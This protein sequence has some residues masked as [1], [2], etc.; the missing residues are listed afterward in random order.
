MLSYVE[1][2]ND[3]PGEEDPASFVEETVPDSPDLICTL[4]EYVICSKPINLRSYQTYTCTKLK[5]R[6]VG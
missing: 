6:Y 1:G 5:V 3:V 4:Q 2:E